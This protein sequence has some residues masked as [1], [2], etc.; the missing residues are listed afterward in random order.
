MQEFHD[1]DALLE[2]VRSLREETERLVALADANPAAPASDAWTFND[3]IAHLTS[4]RLMTAARLEAALRG[5]EPETPWP[6]PLNE[7]D[8]LDEINRWFY[9]TNHDKPRAAL[10][11]ESR[12]TFTRVEQ[13]I[14]ALPERDLF[15]VDRF[16]WLAGYALGPAVVAGTVDHF[17]EHEPELRAFVGQA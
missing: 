2:A 7:D 16:P 13:A 9:E 8:D 5:E 4:W 14:A 6:A 11:R 3:V 1:R 10:L 12:E 17:R 15:T